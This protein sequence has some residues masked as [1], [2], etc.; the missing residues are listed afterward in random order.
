MA[1]RIGT[2]TRSAMGRT[3]FVLLLGS[4]ASC[5]PAPKTAEQNVD[6]AAEE[7]ALRGMNHSFQ[8]ALTAKD[9]TALANF[10]AD[11][12]RVMPPNEPRVEGR[13]AI[14]RKWGEFLTMPG[15]NLTFASD[16]IVI[17]ESGDLAYDTGTYQTRME[18]ESK[19]VDDVGKYVTVF[20]KVGGEW[21]IV[22]DMFNS[23]RAP[24]SSLN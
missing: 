15:F 7:A 18:I 10:Y 13:D 16:R 21:K 17:S 14:R 8:A 3:V 19:P 9:S 6:L 20:K 23:D 5:A 1:N 22:A 2:W 12:A 11:E 24:G 4:L